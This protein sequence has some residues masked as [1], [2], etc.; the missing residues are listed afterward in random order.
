MVKHIIFDL[1]GTLIDSAP[2]ILKCLETVLLNKNI[3]PISPLT[4][5]IIGPPLD[6]TLRKITGIDDVAFINSL[7]DSFKEI[8]DLDGYKESIPYDGIEQALNDIKNSGAQ[9]HLATNKRIIPTKRILEYFSWDIFFNSVYALD[10][11]LN[12]FK[13]KS[14]MLGAILCEK[15]IDPLLAIYIGDINADF[16]A[17]NINKIPFIFAEWG[18]EKKG[19]FNYPLA[20]SHARDLAKKLLVRL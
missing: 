4:Y 7:I 20:V 16:E 12:K 17:A 6:I 18:Y 1:D 19:V 9:I 13:N 2:S 14:E 15:N 8:Y 5:K 11:G 3:K 10:A